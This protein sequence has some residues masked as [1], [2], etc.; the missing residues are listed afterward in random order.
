VI[1]WIVCPAWMFAA[2]GMA[3]VILCAAAA[4]VAVQPAIR[5]EPGRVFRA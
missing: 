2:V 4:L 1:T 5:I 3:L